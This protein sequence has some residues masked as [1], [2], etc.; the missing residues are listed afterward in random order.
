M[1]C[2]Q[3]PYLSTEVW[4]M[5]LFATRTTDIPASFIA[6]QHLRYR[7]LIPSPWACV[8]MHNE[9][10]PRADGPGGTRGK[11]HSLAPTYDGSG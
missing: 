4:V 8:I 11:L 2:R 3:R 10:M 9:K 5:G 7:H 1:K 6:T